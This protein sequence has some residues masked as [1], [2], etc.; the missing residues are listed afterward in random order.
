MINTYMFSNMCPQHDRF[1][2]GIWARLESRVRKWTNAKGV[3]YVIS[4]AIFDK[5]GDENRDADS[6]ANRMTSDNG[7]E[8]VAVPTHFYKII[9]HERPNG[10]IESMTFLLP[11]VDSTP[12]GNQVDPFLKSK[13]VK[14]DDI[15]KITGVDFLVSIRDSDN[16]QAKERVIENFKSKELWPTE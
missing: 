8:R 5:D 6:D 10:F 11:H 14:I 12:T 4:G 9:L 13:L 3:V 7:N 16:G 2:R 1:N 15:E